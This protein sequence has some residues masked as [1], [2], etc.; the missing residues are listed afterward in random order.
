MRTFMCNLD[1][2]LCARALPP[3]V[4]ILRLQPD[5]ISI[6]PIMSCRFRLHREIPNI[7]RVPPVV[8]SLLKQ[9]PSLGG[10]QL[11]RLL[12]ERRDGA[13]DAGKRIKGDFFLDVLLC[14]TEGF[15]RPQR[16]VQTVFNHADYH[17][18]RPLPVRAF[19]GIGFSDTRRLDGQ[20]KARADM[21]SDSLG[22][23]LQMEMGKSSQTRGGRKKLPRVKLNPV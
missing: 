21:L 15:E 12:L 13:E 16:R 14:G 17:R 4:C 22:C 20:M 7:A 3:S 8:A 18:P 11:L 2:R 6:T 23:D 9:H 1:V 5:Q 10:S 19:K